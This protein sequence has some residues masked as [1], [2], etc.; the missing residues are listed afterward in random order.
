MDI[1]ISYIWLIAG[2]LMLFVEA[3]GLPGVGI[4]FAGVGA[5]IV[6]MALKLGILSDVDLVAQFSLFFAATAVSAIALW[7]PLQKFRLGKSPGYSNMVG[8]TAYVG[9]SGLSH[10][11]GGEVT[12]SGTIMRAKIAE[13]AGVEHIAAGTPVI[14]T[15]I[16]GTTLIVKPAK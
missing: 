10:A 6:G 14:I 2:V 3:F 9:A 1:A 7:K 5:I 12:W 15:A 13:H 16:S 8:D 4:M 11:Q